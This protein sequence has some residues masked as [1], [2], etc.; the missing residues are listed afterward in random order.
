MLVAAAALL[1]RFALPSRVEDALVVKLVALAAPS[2]GV[3][4]VGDVESTAFPLPVVAAATGC[5]LEFVPSTVALAGTD[6][7]LILPTLVAVCSSC[8]SSCQ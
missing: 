2:T 1:K 6:P 7:P 3:V 4:K 5:P 8:P